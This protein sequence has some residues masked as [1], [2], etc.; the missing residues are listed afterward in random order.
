[1]ILV[2]CSLST[3]GQV[4]GDI[5]AD[6]FPEDNRLFIPD[7]LHITQEWI[8]A[9]G[10]N[11]LSITVNGA[12]DPKTRYFG[13]SSSMEVILK[14]DKHRLEME[15]EEEDY[16]MCMILFDENDISYIDRE[17]SRIVFIPFF[18]CTI[19]PWCIWLKKPI[20]HICYKLLSNCM[21]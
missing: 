19:N 8:D 17:G 6:S 9:N 12:C 4:I 2:F 10:E 14:N 11:L 13:S 18:Y 5:E 3:Q 21:L 16:Q 1:M 15:Y 20:T 7:T